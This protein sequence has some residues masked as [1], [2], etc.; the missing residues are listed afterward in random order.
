M[1]TFEY[2]PATS[3]Q[4]LLFELA[5][6]L[7]DLEEMLLADFAG[8]TLKMIEVFDRH[9]Y[10]RR[11]IKKN[12]KDIL[13]RME[14]AGKIKGVPPHTNRRKIKGEITCAD[15]TLFTFPP[16]EGKI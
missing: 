9:N 2:S 14:C 7:D 4:P 10:G 12:Y 11:Y 8:R 1:P 16:K 5:R 3:D 13:T 15:E 6:P